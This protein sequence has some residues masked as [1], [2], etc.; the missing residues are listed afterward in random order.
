MRETAG[1]RES[2][3]EADGAALR[4]CLGFWMNVDGFTGVFHVGLGAVERSRPQEWLV[5]HLAL[6]YYLESWIETLAE[7]GEIE[8]YFSRKFN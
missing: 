1:G 6:S 3:D 8:R 5:T 4:I 2:G 7:I